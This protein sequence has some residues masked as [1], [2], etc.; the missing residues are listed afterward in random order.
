MNVLLLGSGGR[1][2]AL[3]WKIAQSP[4]LDRLYIAP[5]NPG[6]ASLGKNL[7]L[8]IVDFGQV[9]AAVIAYQIELLV[10]GPEAPLVAGLTDYLKHS[11]KTPDLLIVGPGAIGA[12]LEGSKDFAKSFMMRHQIPTAAYQSFYANQFAEAVN[13]LDTL[14]PPYVIKADGLAAGK[15][16]V[17]CIEKQ[18]AINT[19]DDMLLK[20]RFGKAS[21]KVVIEEFLNGIELSVFVLTDGKQFCLLPEAKDYKRIGEGDKGP[22]TGGM[23]AISPVP[24]ANESFLKKVI[25]R[26]IE[27]TINGLA[28]ENIDYKGFIFFGLINVD[29]NPMV[30]EYNARM[31]DPE[32]EVVIPRIAEDILPLLIETAKG[33][34]KTGK[35]MTDSRYAATVMMVSAGYPGDYIKGNPITIKGIDTTDLVFHAGSALH[36][37]TGQLVTTGGRVLAVTAYGMNVEDAFHKAY[38]TVRNISFEGAYYRRDLGKDL[39][40]ISVD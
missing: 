6:T 5:G 3:A 23:G 32:T 8:N 35:V 16:V 14:N 29:N 38:Q 22:N 26:I 11:E 33:E 7:S 19:L 13:F 31:G 21:G 2:N 4:L 30:I 34:L 18:E 1:E 15:G 20:G 24:F 28:V 40:N 12:Q 27:P 10:I 36:P 39:A 9:E 37:A 25:S 17:I